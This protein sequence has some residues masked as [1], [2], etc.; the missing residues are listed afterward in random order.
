MMKQQQPARTHAYECAC[1]CAYTPS[2]A[3]GGRG[4]TQGSSRGGARAIMAVA[5]RRGDG[6]GCPRRVG[7]RLAQATNSG[8]GRGAGLAKRSS[9][10]TNQAAAWHD[11]VAYRTVRTTDKHTCPVQL[12]AVRT[13]APVGCTYSR[14]QLSPG[15]AMQ[16]P[17]GVA[18]RHP[19]SRRKHAHAYI[20]LSSCTCCSRWA[21]APLPSQRPRHGPRSKDAGST[22]MYNKKHR[23]NKMHTSNVHPRMQTCADWQLV[24]E[25]H[26]S[27]HTLQRAHAVSSAATHGPACTTPG[28]RQSPPDTNTSS[29]I[30]TCCATQQRS[31]PCMHVRGHARVPRPAAEAQPPPQHWTDSHGVRAVGS[32]WYG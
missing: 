24:S 17:W 27:N 5:D 13:R 30:A 14:G 26:S 19:A 6:Q 3:R 31:R 18:S 16:A 20:R 10:S 28:R 2:A 12:P 22:D 23:L 8:S 21:L 9:P 7:G 15:E 25:A 29:H 11:A 1:G 32:G 4:G